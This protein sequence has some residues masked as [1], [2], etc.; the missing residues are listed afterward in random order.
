MFGFET[1]EKSVFYSTGCLDEMC[2]EWCNILCI[3]YLK[4]LNGRL[5]GPKTWDRIV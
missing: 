2:D 5:I 1:H 4:A 3:G